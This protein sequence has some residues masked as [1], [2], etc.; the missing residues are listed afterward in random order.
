M[1]PMNLFL[2]TLVY[3]S[4]HFVLQI[5]RHALYNLLLIH[6]SNIKSFEQMT[7]QKRHKYT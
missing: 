4:K 7:L 2:Y 6:V 1:S 3:I 5:T